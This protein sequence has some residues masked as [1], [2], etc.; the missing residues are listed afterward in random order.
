MANKAKEKTS[1]ELLVEEIQSLGRTHGVNTV[2]TNFLELTALALAIQLDPL[3]RPQMRAAV[4]Q[5]GDSHPESARISN[6]KQHNRKEI[7]Q[8][9]SESERS[10]RRYEEIDNRAYKGRYCLL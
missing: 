7:L 6:K 1:G 10:N 2:F 3:N 8:Y 4:R 9:E 5:I